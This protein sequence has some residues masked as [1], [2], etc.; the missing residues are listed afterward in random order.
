MQAVTPQSQVQN[1]TPLALCVQ[2]APSPICLVLS[3]QTIA[4]TVLL[5]STHLGM[6]APRVATAWLAS[7]PLLQV[8]LAVPIVLLANTPWQWQLLAQ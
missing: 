3:L 2:Q 5:A 7:I 1:Q 6:A 8:L 4:A